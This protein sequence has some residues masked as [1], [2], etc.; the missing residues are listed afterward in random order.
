MA[1]SVIEKRTKAGV[2]DA[3][4]PHAVVG[5]FTRHPD[6]GIGDGEKVFGVVIHDKPGPAAEERR[7]RRQHQTAAK[8]ELA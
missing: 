2:F 4:G 6:A 8:R 3:R 7:R 5:E 1:A